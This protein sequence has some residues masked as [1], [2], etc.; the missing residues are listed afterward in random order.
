MVGGSIPPRVTFRQQKENK[1][2]FATI[3][4][5]INKIW[6]T[7][8]DDS[9]VLDTIRQQI[10]ALIMDAM[11]KNLTGGV[12]TAFDLSHS[13]MGMFYKGWSDVNPETPALTQPHPPTTPKP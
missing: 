6:H 10:E 1:M 5:E 8:I 7:L 11:T 12:T 4:L 2:S 13:I 9:S 3:E